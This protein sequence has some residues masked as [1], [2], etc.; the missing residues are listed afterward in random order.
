MLCN[1]PKAHY[2]LSL[3][4]QDVQNFPPVQEKDQGGHFE[5]E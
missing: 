4:I 1:R 2:A 5:N 3:R